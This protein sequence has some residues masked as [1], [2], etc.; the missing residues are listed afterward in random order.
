LK[1]NIDLEKV[2]QSFVRCWCGWH[3]TASPLAHGESRSTEVQKDFQVNDPFSE[4]NQILK[5]IFPAQKNIRK[6]HFSPFIAGASILR[7]IFIQLFQMTHWRLLERFFVLTRVVRLIFNS[8][9][10]SFLLLI[11]SGSANLLHR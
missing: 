6:T 8:W 11:K 3:S 9:K 2:D 5:K 7:Y 1:F 10:Y 4:K